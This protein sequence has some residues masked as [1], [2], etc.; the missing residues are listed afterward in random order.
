MGLRNVTQLLRNWGLSLSVISHSFACLTPINVIPG[1]IP[2]LRVIDDAPAPISAWAQ[3]NQ[4]TPFLLRT[5]GL[6]IRLF[7]GRYGGA[8]PPHAQAG[9]V[10]HG[11]EMPSH[12]AVRVGGGQE[13]HEDQDFVSV[14]PERPVE[15]ASAYFR[16]REHKENSKL[17]PARD[18]IGRASCRER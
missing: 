12:H 10:N 15:Q 18:E 13:V 3:A 11:F 6:F 7:E 2:V 14:A 1:K 16:V 17:P 9:L 8:N 5:S 4:A